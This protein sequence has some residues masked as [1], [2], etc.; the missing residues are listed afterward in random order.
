MA[1]GRK[2]CQSGVLFLE[3]PICSR[4]VSCIM[5]GESSGWYT[6]SMKVG[7]GCVSFRSCWIFRRVFMYIS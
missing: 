1:L 6:F 3:V 5:R 4:L 7:F 2:V